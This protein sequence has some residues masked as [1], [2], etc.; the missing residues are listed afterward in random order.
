MNPACLVAS[1]VALCCFVLGFAGV[2]TGIGAPAVPVRTVGLAASERPAGT[3]PL[4]ATLAADTMQL[5]KDKDFGGTMTQISDVTSKPSWQDHD[6]TGKKANDFTSLRWNLP[7][8]V[9]VLLHQYDRG[10]GN[11]L[12]LF[13]SGEIASLKTWKLSDEISSWSWNYVGGTAK[14]AQ[15][16]LDGRAPRPRYAQELEGSV[17]D[18]SLQLF[19]DN[20][21]K[22][23]PSALERV[24]ADAAT[25]GAFRETAGVGKGVSSLRWKLPEGVLVVFSEGENGSGRQLALWGGG[26]FDEIDNFNMNDRTAQ[27]AWYD[28][29]EG[30]P[31]E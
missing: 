20:S 14:P 30:S 10:L 8:G 19:K 3:A 17:P 5:F 18:D 2:M 22:G 1:R 21:F 9:V 12:A 13:G 31:P 29:R 28:V 25:A 26:Q 7:R 4:S 15:R 11:T 16:V 6:F 24:S 27:W 23:K